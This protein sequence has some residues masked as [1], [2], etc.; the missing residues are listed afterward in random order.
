ML[1]KDAL[2]LFTESGALLTS[3]WGWTL[4]TRSLELCCRLDPSFGSLSLTKK[5][6]CQQLHR[7]VLHMKV[8]DRDYFP[9]L[10][11]R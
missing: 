2:D 11:D 9:M 10:S 8:S 6:P 5:R 7:F 1:S 3:S 4:S